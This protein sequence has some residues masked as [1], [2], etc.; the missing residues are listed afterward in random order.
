MSYN[1]VFAAENNQDEKKAFTLVELLVV[2]AI[3]G[4]LAGLLIPAVQAVRESG[5]KT[6]CMNNIKQLSLA[7]HNYHSANLAF[8][9]G[10]FYNWKGKEVAGD[11]TNIGTRLSAF[12][13]LLPYCEQEGLYAKIS[14]NHFCYYW[15]S[16][17]PT[18]NGTPIGDSVDSG[19]IG[20]ENPPIARLH[21]LFCPS[22]SSGPKNS[23]TESGRTNYRIAY[24]DTPVHS[25]IYPPF[26]TVCKEVR[27]P[28]AFNDWFAERSI[29]DGTSNT[30]V[31][32]ERVISTIPQDDDIRSAHFSYPKGTYTSLTR[33]YT[34]VANPVP[35]YR[36]KNYDSHQNGMGGSRWGDG[37]A[38]Y[39]GFCTIFRPNSPCA[40]TA[41]VNPTLDP[42]FGGGT[43][44]VRT[45]PAPS[46]FH[47][48]GVNVGFADGSVH[49]IND[50]ID[51]GNTDPT[52][53][54]TYS[55]KGESMFGVWGAL[56]SRN[57]GETNHGKL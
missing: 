33:S 35:S 4:V 39:T 24:G 46:G 31:F 34:S 28:F 7:I 2:I 5:R 6:Q 27:G 26:V 20:A 10:C 42:V 21:F 15:N 56:G 32:S 44:N 25:H 48:G 51:N 29:V 11:G 49:Y 55:M 13:V 50:N 8:P 57:G 18:G 23:D 22:D 43:D 30:V 3:I 41:H 40:G 38:N 54:V 19:A 45:M 36:G 52:G 47:L 37:E 12:I 14:A 9:A 16:K 17:N 53:V 1:N